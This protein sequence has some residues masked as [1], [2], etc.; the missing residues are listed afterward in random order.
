MSHT[1]FR[2]IRFSCFDVNWIQQAN[3]ICQIFFREI[4]PLFTIII[5]NLSETFTGVIWVATKKCPISYANKLTN[6]KTNYIYY[7]GR[8]LNQYNEDDFS[9]KFWFQKSFFSNFT[10]KKK[11]AVNLKLLFVSLFCVS[12]RL[13]SLI[14]IYILQIESRLHCFDICDNNCIILE[15]LMVNSSLRSLMIDEMNLFGSFPPIYVDPW[16]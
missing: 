2:P 4:R 11:E 1:K 8:R 9:Y 16:V 15:E 3:S 7:S 10:S 12:M 6:K 5:F 14:E 13:E